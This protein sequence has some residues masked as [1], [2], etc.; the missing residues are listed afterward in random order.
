MTVHMLSTIDNP[1]NPW[2]HYDEWYN[3]DQV[4]GYC[5]ISFLGRIV[6]SSDELSQ[7][8]QDQAIEDAIEE[9]VKENVSG[10]YIRVPEPTG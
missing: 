9:I 4:A 2:T 6:R 5:T 7:T 1:Y 8:D 10:I 3:F